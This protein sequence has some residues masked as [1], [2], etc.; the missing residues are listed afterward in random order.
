[1]RLTLP[2]R[3][4]QVHLAVTARTGWH[5]AAIDPASVDATSSAKN[6]TR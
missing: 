6:V 2:A 4:V 5:P 3:T 1:M